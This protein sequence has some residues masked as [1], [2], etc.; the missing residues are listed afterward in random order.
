MSYT[1]DGHCGSV[2]YVKGSDG[3]KLIGI[4]G[5]LENSQIKNM[6]APVAYWFPFES[7]HNNTDL[8]DMEEAFWNGVGYIS[9]SHKA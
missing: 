3:F 1:L 2:L 8:L 7:L 9:N 5:N 4:H 6:P